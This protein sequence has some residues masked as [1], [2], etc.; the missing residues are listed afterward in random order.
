M[1]DNPPP[2]K[3]SG[4]RRFSSFAAGH[5]VLAVTA[6][7]CAL[8]LLGGG[9]ATASTIALGAQ[10]VGTQYSNGLQ[11]STGQMIQP[12]GD[13][14]M[15]PFGKLMGSAVSPDGRYLVGTSTD[16][17]V[18]LQVFDLSTYK[19]VAAAGTLAAASFATAAAN[20]GYANMA[21]LKI[22]DGTVGQEGPVFSPDGKFLFAPVATGIV[23][24]PFNADGSLGGGTKI[25]IPTAGGLRALT[26]GM[27]FSP[28][29]RPS[30]PRSMART[31]WSPSTRP[32]VRSSRLSPRA[33]PRAS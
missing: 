11:I 27:A 8:A 24:Y 14:V 12:I 28:T 17:S 5:R 32:P 19:P 29:A 15:T 9:I 7:G 26:A 23:R 3:Q 22:S 20:A 25:S 30:M 31:P 1:H 16:L 10:Q 4:L 13:R 18:D 2:R 6:A 33:S 21:Y